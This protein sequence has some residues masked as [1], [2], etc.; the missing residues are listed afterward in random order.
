[1][2]LISVPPTDKAITS[3]KEKNVDRVRLGRPGGGSKISGK[4]VQM[5][6]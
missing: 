5:I 3:L 1:M 6:V 4:G 2:H